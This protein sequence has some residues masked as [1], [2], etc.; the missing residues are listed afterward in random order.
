MVPAAAVGMAKFPDTTTRGSS[1]DKVPKRA[2]TS[3]T[4]MI[5]SGLPG[6]FGHQLSEE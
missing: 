5:R 4:E 1:P 6:Q 3:S 2:P